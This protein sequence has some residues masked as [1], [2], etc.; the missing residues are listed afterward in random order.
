MAALDTVGGNSTGPRSAH[1][2]RKHQGALSSTLSRC[3]FKSPGISQFQPAKPSLA[4]SQFR[5]ICRTTWA[6]LNRI[7]VIERGTSPVEVSRFDRSQHA[8]RSLLRSGA[9]SGSPHRP[10]VQLGRGQRGFP[11]TFK[12][13]DGFQRQDASEWFPVFT[14]GRSVVKR[15]MPFAGPPRG[16]SEMKTTKRAKRRKSSPHRCSSVARRMLQHWPI[17][18]VSLE[19]SSTK[20]TFL[21]APFEG[22]AW[23]EQTATCSP[24]PRGACHLLS[25]S[26]ILSRFFDQAS[27]A[28]L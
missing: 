10:D 8:E 23:V 16:R 18:G 1:D 26:P 5:P 7:L 14:T 13:T 22:P 15:R 12:R 4:M 3:F 24:T 27:S 17:A 21:L 6:A 28:R 19:G 11:S 9:P 20:M 2:F 25:P